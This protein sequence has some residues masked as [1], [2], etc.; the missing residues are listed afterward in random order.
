MITV[1]FA[2]TT[3][4]WGGGEKWHFEMASFLKEKGFKVVIITNKNS[5][6][7]KR[8]RKNNIE[9]KQLSI[10]NLSF[11]NPLKY[12]VIS[13]ILAEISPDI[14]ILNSPIDI[15]TIGVSAANQNVKHIIYRRGSD[16]AIKNSFLNRIYFKHVITGIIANSKATKNSILKNNPELFP[17]NKIKVIYN[18]LEVNKFD[19]HPPTASPVFVIGNLGRLVYQKNQRALIDLA[20]ILKGEIKNFKIRIG[21]GG[22]LLQTLTEYAKEKQVEH[23]IEFTG[24]VKNPISF[25]KDIDL[26]VLP[27]HWEGFGYVIAE[28]S[29]L[30]KPV[31]AYHVSS[32]PELIRNKETG[33][34]IK[35]D[36]LEAMKDSIL[37]LY[38]SSEMRQKF[39]VNGRKFILNNFDAR[40]SRA[41]TLAYINKLLQNNTR[42]V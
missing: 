7:Y 35:K 34:L 14:I 1:C 38:R 12:R 2:N 42:T 28:A 24:E 11:L 13:N 3:K 37:D 22:P 31:I 29:L 30:E 25:L 17:K 41:E 36:D 16:I 21:G 20:V 23:L 5:E 40:N 27:S 32:N 39:G 18:G 33:Y 26:F 8:A 4:S 9:V 6:L 15:K 10:N 19:V